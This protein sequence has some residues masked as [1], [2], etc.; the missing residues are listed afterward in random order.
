MLDSA[1]AIAFIAAAA[2]APIAV[3]L[4][5]A[6][7]LTVIGS[8]GRNRWI[9]L[10]AVLLLL[11][12]WILLF[13]SV[14]LFYSP[15][16]APRLYAPFLGFLL[17]TWM[18]AL[19]AAAVSCVR[20]LALFRNNRVEALLNLIASVTFGSLYIVFYTCGDYFPHV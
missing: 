10:P 18:L 3:S 13:A 19:P 11:V 2:V 12:A 7:A 8:H 16:D 9:L 15:G 17:L 14:T 20:G 4:A 6:F 5:A 1:L